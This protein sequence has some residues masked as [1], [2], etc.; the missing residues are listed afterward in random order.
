MATLGWPK[1][2]Y[3]PSPSSLQVAKDLSRREVAHPVCPRCDHSSTEI[4]TLKNR[5][6]QAFSV[7]DQRGNIL[8]LRAIWLVLKL[9]S[10]AIVMQKMPR[11]MQKWIRMAVFQWNHA[12]KQ[13][14]GW[15][16]L[17]PAVKD[18]LSRSTKTGPHSRNVT[19]LKWCFNDH[20]SLNSHH[21]D[22]WGKIC[23]NTCA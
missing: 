18:Y 23:C 13:A 21:Y 1:N 5:S 10:S 17:S 3:N 15:S 20:S 22:N 6:R 4:T 7:T 12:Q 16:L 19:V 9:P 2:N 8:D 11:M 14:V